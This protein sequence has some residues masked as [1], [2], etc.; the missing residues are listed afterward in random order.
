MVI[1]MFKVDTSKLTQTDLKGL[2]NN[3]KSIFPELGLNQV[4]HNVA[5]IFGAQNWNSI[6]ASI[7]ED[8]NTT[9]NPIYMLQRIYIGDSIDDYFV[10]TFH[11][12]TAQDAYDKAVIF[13]SDWFS[14]HVHGYY[15]FEEIGLEIEDKNITDI[16]SA[17]VIV[18]SGLQDGFQTIDDAELESL[19]TIITKAYLEGGVD[20]CSLICENASSK[21]IIEEYGYFTDE[22]IRLIEVN[23]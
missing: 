1:I 23:L 17:S 3:A 6:S 2:V 10:E 12:K 20:I 8:L 22:D 11:A 4:R 21:L 16:A 14:D 18:R 7:E 9:D 15:D 5:K 19:A 13:A